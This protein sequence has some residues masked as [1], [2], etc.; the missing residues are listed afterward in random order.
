M[1]EYK[2]GEIEPKWQRRWREAKLHATVFDPSKPKYYALDMFPY[3]SGSGLHVGHCEGYTATDIITRWKRMQGYN[4]LHPMGWDAFG[5]PAENFAIK[6]GIHPKIT[7]EKAIANFHRQIDS[8]GFCY[9][10][11]REINTT[12]PEY[13][14]WTQWIFLLLFK[15]GLAYEGVMP[16]NWCPSCKTGLANEEVKNGLCDRCGAKVERRSLRQWLLR[17]TRYAD[18][19]LE[20]LPEV[21]WPESTLLMQKNW[22]GRSVGAEVVFCVASG[23]E[24]AMELKVFTTRPDTLFGAT[25]LVVSPEHPLVETLTTP[26]RQADVEAYRAKAR[27]KSDLERTDLAKNKTGVFT[28]SYA[29]NPVNGNKIPVW[30][31]DYVLATYGTGAIMAVPAH[32]ERDFQFAVKFGLPIVE[33]VR[34]IEGATT[35]PDAAFIGEGVNVNSE[36][37]DGMPTAEASRVIIERLETLH[38]GK[39]AV[40]YKLRDWLFSRQR[41]WGEPIPIVHCVD[42]GVVAVPEN[43]LPVLLPEVD[44]YEPSGTGESP[45]AAMVSWVETVCPQCGKPA[46]RETNT[47]P[48]WAGSCWYYLRYLDTRNAAKAWEE[49]NERRWM[50]VDLYIGGAEH[51]VLH[52]LYARFWHKV[53]F[54]CGLVSTKEP[55]KKLRHQGTVLARTFCDKAGKYHEFSEVAFRDDVPYLAATGERLTAEVEKMAKSKLNGINPDDVIK[56]YGADTLRLYEMFMGD[57][58]QPKP[59]DPRAIEGCNRFL[60]RL[61]RLVDEAAEGKT[62][63]EQLHLRLRHRVIKQVSADLERMQFNTAI[64][65]M[66]EYVNELTAKGAAREDL[67]VLIRLLAPYAPHI[68]DEAW[69]RLGNSG[70]VLNQVWPSFDDALTQDDTAT[71]VVQVNGKLRG[72]FNAPVAA[73][74]LDLETQARLLEKVKPFIDGKAIKKVIVVPKKLVNFVVIP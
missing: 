43:Q 14:K 29:V 34:P 47:M 25:Y 20:D 33:V 15:R 59:W 73:S 4:V 8:V 23:T 66:M 51:A 39:K 49:R 28:G 17:I 74:Q 26:D 18:R 58:E 65:R 44:K 69:E 11:D 37:L 54:D 27:L 16:I 71:I 5:L 36:I 22:I 10:W 63:A 19:L 50:N 56:T 13:Y 48:Q 41:Y 70:F 46:K 7:T 40:S 55:F 42:C 64:A 35:L 53:L 57:F 67:L 38:A 2:P 6:T 24:G 52:L 72:Q 31:A 62:K 1:G 9:D 30:T 45:L 3:P 60:R 61:F 32:D 21:D 68:A 12:S